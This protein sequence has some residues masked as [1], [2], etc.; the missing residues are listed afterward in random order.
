M[1]KIY[2]QNTHCKIVYDETEE[3]DKR[4][5]EDIL[6]NK[7]KAEDSAL[8]Y[9]QRTRSKHI[10]AYR[11][12]YIEEKN[13][14]PVGFLPFLE[15]YYKQEEIEYQINDLR[16][17]PSVDKEFLREL[18]EDRYSENG[19][20]PR[21]YQ[22]SAV[23]RVLKNRGGIVQLSMGSGKTYVAYILCKAYREHK[24]LLLFNRVNLVHQT[25]EKFIEYGMDENEIGVIQGPN[26]QDDKRVTLLSVDSYEKA[27]GLFP[28]IKVLIADEAHEVGSG[29]GS[30][31][32]TKVLWSCQ[33]APIRIGLSAT[34]DAIDNNY[35]QMALYGNLG[36]IV[37]DRQIKDQVDEGVLA[38]LDIEMHEVNCDPIPICGSYADIYEKQ[39]IKE[40]DKEVVE[41]DGWEFVK[42]GNQYYARHFQQHGDE[43]THYVFNDYRNK[44]IAELAK[45][46]KRVMILFVRKEH[47]RRLKELLPDAILVDGDNTQEERENA[48]EFLKE[49]KDNIILASTIFG[50]G[51]DIPHIHTLI[52]AGGGRGT[53]P[54]IQRF[55]R[56][57]RKDK[58]TEK[59]K[60][61]II[62]FYDTFSNLAISQSKRRKGIYEDKLGFKVKMI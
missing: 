22:I 60:A 35:R 15:E 33:N 37:I 14:L 45:K 27:Y 10:S 40:A 36:P 11:S 16:K 32:A 23:K 12:F 20:I 57:T 34:A 61:K 43:S 21:D 59:E 41:H 7:F 44:K 5:S 51:V 26:F 24:I 18:F 13:L 4:V 47:G 31:Q 54:V 3:N 17:Y 25:R 28:E 62:D 53:V 48:K 55:G 29:D 9:L 39:K 2:A 49:H 42:E 46:H 58:G 8:K 50:Q 19:Y 52:L 6:K 38:D 30:D 1:I 56:A